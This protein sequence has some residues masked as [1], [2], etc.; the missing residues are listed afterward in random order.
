MATANTRHSPF[1][2]A[3]Q[4]ELMTL[5]AGA[6]LILELVITLPGD[7]RRFSP[8]DWDG[9]YTTLLFAKYAY[10]LWFATY[11]FLGKVQ[12]EAAKERGDAMSGRELG[13]DFL[14]VGAS[15]IAAWFL[16]FFSHPV[17]PPNRDGFVA[18]AGSIFV[19]SVVSMMLFRDKDSTETPPTLHHVRLVGTT[20]PVSRPPC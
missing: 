13:F 2:R 5:V 14:Q 17:D 9:A 6:A 19:I 20:D 10:L 11:F 7:L 15:I 18:A 8:S 12:R 3:I 4:L 16:G 1:A